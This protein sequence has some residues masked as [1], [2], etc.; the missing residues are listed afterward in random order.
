MEIY[1]KVSVVIELISGNRSYPLIGLETT[2]KIT[3]AVFSGQD[4]NMS[5]GSSHIRFVCSNDDALQELLKYR[6]CVKNYSTWS[7]EGAYR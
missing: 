2:L 6:G 7:E 4:F 3:V 1:R 5:C